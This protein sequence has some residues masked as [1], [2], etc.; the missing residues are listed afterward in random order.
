MIDFY[1]TFSEMMVNYLSKCHNRFIVKKVQVRIT[2]YKNHYVS[3]IVR[4]TLSNL[5][6]NDVTGSGNKIVMKM[7][8][9]VKVIFH[10]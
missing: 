10:K 9:V 6:A 3:D 4:P 5:S 8:M 2:A 1:K 7:K